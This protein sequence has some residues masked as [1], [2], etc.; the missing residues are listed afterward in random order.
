MTQNPHVGMVWKLESELPA[1]RC[2]F[3][4]LTMN[5]NY[6]VRRQCFTEDRFVALSPFQCNALHL[7]CVRSKVT[8]KPKTWDIWGISVV[9]FG[10]H[11]R[12]ILGFQECDKEHVETWM[13]SDA[14]DCG[15]QMLNDDDIV[16][17]EQKESDP[18][19]DETDEEEDNNNESS[20]GPSNA[21]AFSELRD[22]YG[23]VR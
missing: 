5:Q 3:H 11:L 7:F 20:K 23:V 17:S 9:S 13:A 14:E 8:G 10:K 1:V 18:V 19:D 22:S 12:G 21:D 6:E 16:T 2:F 4:H 15:F